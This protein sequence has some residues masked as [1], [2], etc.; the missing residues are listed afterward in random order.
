VLQDDFRV[1]ECSSIKGLQTEMVSMSKI[2]TVIQSLD[3][4]TLDSAACLAFIKSLDETGFDA[5]HFRP[6]DAP[7]GR[8]LL[9][10]S[11]VRWSS[12][13]HGVADRVR[14]F[15][16]RRSQLWNDAPSLF[17]WLLLKFPHAA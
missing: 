14:A 1:N 4:R 17:P 15:G 9:W 6:L 12:S 2:A 11:R 16:P 13:F 8:A 7:F 10:I 5:L 3:S